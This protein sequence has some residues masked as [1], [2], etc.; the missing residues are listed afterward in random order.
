VLE[1]C[2]KV[3][4]ELIIIAVFLAGCLWECSKGDDPW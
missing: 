3:I 4:E 2:I 1:L